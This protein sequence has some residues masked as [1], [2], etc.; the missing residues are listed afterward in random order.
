MVDW[1]EHFQSQWQSKYCLW[2]KNF[3]VFLEQCLNSSESGAW[4]I[5]FSLSMCNRFS[6]RFSSVNNHKNLWFTEKKTFSF[7]T[8][9]ML[10]KKTAEKYTSNTWTQVQMLNLTELASVL[11]WGWLHKLLIWFQCYYPLLWEN[12]CRYL[13][14][15]P[16]SDAVLWQY[17]FEWCRYVDKGPLGIG[18]NHKAIR[19]TFF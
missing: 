5:H 11:P 8:L 15:A 13:E 18:A 6:V 7:L 17:L 4:S 14:T 9:T 2:C 10:K 1:G 16:R 12:R 3:H 19:L